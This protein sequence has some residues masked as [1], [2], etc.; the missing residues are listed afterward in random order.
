MKDATDDNS[1][2]KTNTPDPKRWIHGRPVFDEA[3]LIEMKPHLPPE[4]EWAKEDGV[5]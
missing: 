3:D 2:G 1:T 5:E 4:D